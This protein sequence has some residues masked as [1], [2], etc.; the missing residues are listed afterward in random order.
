M[1]HFN[2]CKEYSAEF[3]LA[4]HTASLMAWDR[5]AFLCVLCLVCGFTTL[6]LS[7]AFT[8]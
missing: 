7:P 6:L 1:N 2:V 3:P 4:F 8:A 5:A